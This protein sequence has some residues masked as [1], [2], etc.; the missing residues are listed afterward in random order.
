MPEYALESALKIKE[1]SVLKRLWDD[2]QE[3][4]NGALRV[5][6]DFGWGKEVGEDSGRKLREFFLIIGGKKG[7]QCGESDVPGIMVVPGSFW[8]WEWDPC[9]GHCYDSLPS[10][11]SW[12]PWRK[13]RLLHEH[14]LRRKK[15]PP[16]CRWDLVAQ[17]WS[18]TYTDLQKTRG[19]G[20]CKTSKFLHV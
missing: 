15:W 13:S 5:E 12:F 18:H 9:L 10:S 20:S 11:E 3:L 6:Q 7:R 14:L 17:G 19:T 8:Q 2:E 4:Q 1:G 16:V